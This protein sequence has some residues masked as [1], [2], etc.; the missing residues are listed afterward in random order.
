MGSATAL[1]LVTR[2]EV[3]EVRVCDAGTRVLKGLRTRVD[4]PK[5]KSYQVDA[6]DPGMLKPIL[7][8]SDCVIG[9]ADPLL[10]P[11]LAN[12]SIDIGAHFCDLGGGDDLVRKELALDDHARERGVWILPACGLAPGLVNV[13][14]LLGIDKFE[15]VTA[16]HLRV[17]ALPQHPEPPF[18][19]RVAFSAQKLLDDYTNPASRIEGGEV[20]QADALSDVEVIS[21]VEPYG[22]L[23]AFCTAGSL[24]TLASE[25]RGDVVTLDMKTIAWPGHAAHM[26]VLLGLGFGS[27]RIIDVRTHLTYRD[28]LARQLTKRLGGDHPDVVLLRVV[29]TGQSEA[30]ERTLVLEMVDRYD[31]E[32]GLSAMSRCTSIPTASVA[33]LLAQGRVPGPGGARPPEAAV[34]RQ[35]LL[36]DLLRRGLALKEVWYDGKRSVA[37]PHRPESS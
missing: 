17:G 36:D 9:C 8:G 35:L 20:V 6:R 21:F 4:S 33:C 27:N 28:V 32:A 2:D 1:D 26:Q 18:N 10:N 29:I 24:T 12:A 31:E 5:L 15:S 25:L 7:E 13:L 14:C 3:S 34:P 30:R 23:E 22:R 37:D 11:A 16:A 19:F